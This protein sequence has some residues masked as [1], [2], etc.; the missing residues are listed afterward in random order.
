M[1][2]ITMDGVQLSATDVDSR[3]VDLSTIAEGSLSG[4]T[5]T[6]AITSDMDG[7]AI[8][9]NVNFVT[10]VAPATRTIQATVQGI[11]DGMDKTYGQYNV[12][13]NYGERFFDDVFGVQVFGN[14]ERRVRSSENFSV[15]Y[16]QNVP[17]GGVEDWNISSF[18]VQYV[19]EVRTRKGGKVILD[20]DA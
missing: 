1:T 12:Y 2:T 18:S 20:E 5:L 10:K 14:I 4:I 15:S 6:K 3:G 16:N 9:G 11:Y 7:Q 13:G 19:P 8:A 17:R